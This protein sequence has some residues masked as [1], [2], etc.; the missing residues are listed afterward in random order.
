VLLRPVVEAAV[1]PT[2]AYVAGPGELSY[3]AQAE[4]LYDLLGVSRQ[5]FV[6]RAG[7]ALIDEKIGRV[8]ERYGLAPADLAVPSPELAHRV[9][10]DDLPAAVTAA[11]G[12]LREQLPAS[13]GELRD[14]AGDVEPTLRR[15]VENRRNQA[16]LGVDRIEHK[17]RS[18]LAR[19]NDSALQRLDRAREAL[20]P[21]G[22]PQERVLSVAS[23]LARE[24]RPA[25]DAAWVAAREHAGGLLQASSGH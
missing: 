5:A 12:R 4:P 23:F 14:A 10:Q 15:T 13:Y 21:A 24:G 17:L 19:R 8:L 11:L 6:P 16:L 20:Y 22:A 2:L 7:G 9:A 18:A 3:L 25:L 1:F